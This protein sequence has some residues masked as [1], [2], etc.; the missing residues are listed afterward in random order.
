MPSY[1]LSYQDIFQ[2][3][4]ARPYLLLD[5]AGLTNPGGA[6]WGLV[7]TGADRTSMPEGYSRLLGYTA[8]DLEVGRSTVA[9]GDTVQV[10]A[11]TKPLKATV[12]GIPNLSVEL[13]PIFVPSSAANVLW[14]RT[15]FFRSFED[16]AF[17]EPDGTFTLTA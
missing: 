8:N 3:G 9:N 10:L 16:V 6:V 13:L 15:D 1:R 4:T 12:V 17:R 2:T 14:G 7:D 5:V 11:A